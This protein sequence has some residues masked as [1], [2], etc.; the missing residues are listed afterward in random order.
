M[1][2]GDA[3]QSWEHSSSVNSM[4]NLSRH[5]TL[6]WAIFLV[7]A[8]LPIP[9]TCFQLPI[10]RH[11]KSLTTASPPLQQKHPLTIRCYPLPP[12]RD[13]Y[14]RNVRLREEAESPFRR[15]RFFVYALLGAGALVSLLLSLA[16]I[17]AASSGINPD[18]LSESV[19]N[20]GIDLVGLVLL[21]MVPRSV[22]CVKTTAVA[23]L[24]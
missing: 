5:K 19:A 4:M 3:L 1:C 10:L 8:W 23:V 6:L 14:S 21:T 9:S 16:R 11:A 7:G 24:R 18:F 20:A 17:A 2:V 22:A 12:R 15:V 13:D